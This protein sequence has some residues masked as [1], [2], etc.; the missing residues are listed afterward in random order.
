[1]P[2][3]ELDHR[4]AEI[5]RRL[6]RLEA[7]LGHAPGATAPPP[8]PVVRVAPPVRV[9]PLPPP[10]S[11]AQPRG[12][13][14][15][16]IGLRWAGWVGAIVLV[17]GAGLG[18]EFAY[19]QG[20]FERFPP[21]ARV[22]L[23]VAAAAALIGAGEWVYR[24]VNVRSAVGL[25]AAGV[26]VLFLA[27]YAGYAFYG[28]YGRGIAYGL[29]A[30]S[31]L[32]GAAVARRGDLLSVAALSIIGG[33]LAPLL[34]GGSGAPPSGFL[35]YLFTLQL[36][37]VALAYGGG[38]K[39]WALR[40]LSLATTAV[41]VASAIALPRFAG[42]T[43]IAFL[44]LYAVVYHAER[45][46]S[47]ALTDGDAAGSISFGACVTAALAAAVLYLTREASAAFRTTE[48]LAMATVAGGAAVA[49]LRLGRNE[50]GLRAVGVGFVVQAV[51]LVVLAVPVATSGAN[52]A[53][54]WGLMA[55]A[56]AVSGRWSTS[57]AYAA[58]LVWVLAAFDL[59]L[60]ADGWS[61]D[62][63]AGDH[64]LTIAGQ[65]VPAYVVVAGLLMAAGHTVAGFTRRRTGIDER[66]AIADVIDGLAAAT[67]LAAGGIGLSAVAATAGGL[68]YAAAA[69]AAVGLGVPVAVGTTVAIAVAVK[70]FAVDAV[71][72]RP[73][74]GVTGATA[75]MGAI[76]VG[77][78]VGT[79]RAN[80]RGPQLLRRGLRVFTVAIGVA[81]ASVAVDAAFARGG[82]SPLAEHVA[83]SVLWA[84]AATGV[85]AAGFGRRLPDL[86]YT[87]LVLF[88]VTL[89]KVV[90]VDL[91][92]VGAG[93]R[94][95]SFLGL[96]AL[97]LLTSVLYGRLGGARADRPT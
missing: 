93:W 47:A 89:L 1:M 37:A 20:W 43:T 60:W 87:G 86:R 67:A 75:V 42:A 24:R 7:I 78:L 13:L 44:V 2:D 72:R 10:L 27:A 17:I 79:G 88:A 85:V 50:G 95:L 61:S 46:A 91:A 76:A 71:L 21:A 16:A 32:V 28:L 8:P 30:G 53:I 62:N 56:L 39:W 90:I 29:M 14:E 65:A 40:G 97:L 22:G 12:T 3:A 70:W 96:G 35:G 58:P 77:V 19:R 74:G 45:V 25:F 82:G 34:L 63:H 54:G 4:M 84:A 31:T 15:Q 80:R 38:R 11:P 66:T 51:G 57:A 68:A 9:A 23:L 36:V 83:L 59:L 52:V 6:D 41:W 94:I 55:V 18:I 92:G 26:A 48:V 5:E 64:W 73:A 81:A 49:C 33:A 69:L